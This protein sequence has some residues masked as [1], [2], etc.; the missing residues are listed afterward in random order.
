MRTRQA[1]EMSEYPSRCRNGRGEHTAGG[2]S[3]AAGLQL[4]P[5]LALLRWANAGAGVI[6]RCR[7][8]GQGRRSVIGAF[9]WEPI[10][11]PMRVQARRGAVALRL[12]NRISPNFLPQ[13][14]F[15]GRL[16]C[17]NIFVLIRK[18]FIM[19]VHKHRRIDF[20]YDDSSAS[21]QSTINS[22]VVE[23]YS[24]SNIPKHFECIVSKYPVR[25]VEKSAFLLLHPRVVLHTRSGV[26]NFPNIPDC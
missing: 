1:Q 13:H 26:V 7:S 20:E 21:I 17:E 9:L 8:G 16:D 22:K 11:R 14:R 19:E 18:E 5:A 24:R 6:C 25:I 3:G 12:V 10:K 23:A 4:V 15:K 2:G